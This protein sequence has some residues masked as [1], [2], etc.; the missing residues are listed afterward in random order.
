V[1]RQSQG[2]KK[3]RGDYHH[4]DLRR[5][6]LDAT[7]T[8]VARRGVDGF[9]LR[10]TARAAGV[11][12]GAPYHHFADKEALL[13]A[14]AEE[15]FRRFREAL[16]QAGERA[17]GDGARA[18]AEAVGVAYVRWAVEHPTEF[19][20]MLG[21]DSA[22]RRARHRGLMRAAAEA[23]QLV[24]RVLVAGVGGGAEVPEA[25]VVGWWSVVHGLAFLM[26]DELVEGGDVE[27]RVRA[28]IAA[29][30]GAATP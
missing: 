4:G 19:R 1:T 21:Q 22:R 8:L 23:Y 13:A 16:A 30:R 20:M 29:L 24:R 12:A 25:T 10:E 9:S 7:V 3:K 17:A 6:L 5:A 11:S 15:G 28:V 27:R 2:R 14:V 26:I 18:E